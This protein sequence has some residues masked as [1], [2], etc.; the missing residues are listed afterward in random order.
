MTSNEHDPDGRKRTL[1]DVAY[2]AIKR[3]ILRVALPPGQQFTE[4]QLSAE[5]GLGKTPVR[6]ALARLQ[7]EELVE[8]MPRCGY[9]VAPLTLKDVQDIFALRIL[10]EGE[11]VRLACKGKFSD[12]QL[13][14]LEE[15]CTITYDVDDP[16]AFTQAITD[17]TAF[18]V[19]LAEGSGN[20]R[21]V[22]SLL[23]VMEHMERV[24]H[25]TI[26][27]TPGHE[28]DEREHVDLLEAVLSGDGER[29]RAVVQEQ[30][31]AWQERM[32]RL[33]LSNE[34][35]L[36]ANLA[37][38]SPARRRVPAGGNAGLREG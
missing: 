32:I 15:L 22:S 36:S 3:D 12:E 4:S 37:C 34:A 29:A 20:R 31:R 33:L 38:G 5:L 17:N 8:V 14:R 16:D 11:A 2:D 10:L 7:R 35:V 23:Q 24:L 9:R 1:T 28:I 27:A 25:I 18:H 13:R 21:L 26:A 6:E 30:N 19:T